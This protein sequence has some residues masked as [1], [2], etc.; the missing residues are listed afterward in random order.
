MSDGLDFKSERRYA[1]YDLDKAIYNYRL[2]AEDTL[3]LLDEIDDLKRKNRKLKKQQV[4]VRPE[5]IREVARCLF[6]EQGADIGLWVDSGE[7]T[8]EEA[9][10]LLP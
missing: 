6:E 5:V 4:P 3:K 2:G 10:W 7:M 1:Q 9:E 8:E